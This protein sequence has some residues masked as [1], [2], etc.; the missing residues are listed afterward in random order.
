M[1]A[2]TELNRVMEKEELAFLLIGIVNGPVLIPVESG[3]LQK[4]KKKKTHEM[5]RY[6]WLHSLVTEELQNHP[7]THYH[8]RSCTLPHF[9]STPPTDPLLHTQTNNG[10][11]TRVF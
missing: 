5:M 9:Y 4:K 8:F 6:L 3:L 2:D 11:T 7:R 10:F 1:E